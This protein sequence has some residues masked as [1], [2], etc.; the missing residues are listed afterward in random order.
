MPALAALAL[1]T[2]TR[3]RHHCSAHQPNCGT[4][5]KQDGRP[6]LLFRIP[7]FACRLSQIHF[8]QKSDRPL[9]RTPQIARTN[10]FVDRCHLRDGT[11]VLEQHD[12]VG[13]TLG[14]IVDQAE[15]LRFESCNPQ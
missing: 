9:H 12:A 13:F 4:G 15:A 1:R 7:Y 6:H 11:I 14:H 10:L 5:I 3:F 8:G 2:A